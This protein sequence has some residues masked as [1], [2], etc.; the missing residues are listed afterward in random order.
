VITK[1]PAMTTLES[2]PR[3]LLQNTILML[4]FGFGYPYFL[5]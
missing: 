5:Q 3:N 4:R 2:I 1:K